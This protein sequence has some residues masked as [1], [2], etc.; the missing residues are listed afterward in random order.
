MATEMVDAD[1]QRLEIIA[2]IRQRFHVAV[3]RGDAITGL[4]TEIRLA[5]SG[6]GLT[7]LDRRRLEWEV[8]RG[9]EAAEKTKQRRAKKPDPKVDPRSVLKAV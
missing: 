5:E 4:A 7:P 2:E 6:F 1:R 8:A 3:D 9:E